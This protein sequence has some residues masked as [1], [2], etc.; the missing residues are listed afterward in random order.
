[1]PELN[2]R[3]VLALQDGTFF[4]GIS[5]GSEG[6]A[7][8]EVV[9]NTAMTGYQE[10]LTD[11][12]YAQQMIT[13]TCP[14]IGNVG[15]N[16]LDEESN[17]I[18]AT[19][20]IIRQL[21][22]IVSN[23][24]AETSLSQYLRYHRIVGIANIDTRKLTH[25]LREHGVLNGCIIAGDSNKEAALLL[26]RSFDGLMGKNLAR[27]VSTQK[28][29]GYLPKK[30]YSSNTYKIIVIDYGV[31]KSILRYLSNFNFHIIVVPVT[32]SAKEILTLKPDGIVLSN[33]PGDPKACHL[34][35]LNIK[36]LINHQIPILGICLGH[37][38][39]ALA[40]GA[41]TVKMKFGHH[42]SNHPIQDLETKT[43]MITSQNHGFIVDE[44]TLPS[45]LVPTHRSLFDGSLQGMRHRYKSIYS[46]QGHPEA[47][48]GPGDALVLFK[49]FIESVQKQHLIVS[50][51]ANA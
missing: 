25:K 6:I 13:F 2:N 17:H 1:M 31:K 7:R 39:L 12:S 40:F 41:T 43:V 4:E 30:K 22:S 47:G 21:S 15:V 49:S 11:P 26:A 37:Q 10:I 44:K 33:G 9:F 18:W 42:G 8:G 23:W 3:A 48:P 36:I 38:L 5:I 50:D 34:E 29:Y 45:F 35:I 32:T 28:P 20:V 27:I 24:R 46:F 51:R 14:H 19:G 16:S